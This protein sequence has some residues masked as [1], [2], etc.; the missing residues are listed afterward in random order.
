MV[1]LVKDEKILLGRKTRKIG[2]G[3]RNG[4]GGGIEEGESVYE[5]ATRELFE[6]AGVSCSIDDIKK[7]AELYFEN[8]TEEGPKW[9]LVV[10][11]FLASSW[12]G[13]P[14]ESEEFEDL[15]WFDFADVPENELM[16][17]TFEWLR[18]ILDGKKVIVR[19]KHGPHQKT[20]IGKQK[21]EEVLDF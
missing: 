5:C 11:T 12:Q 20:L 7:S 14:K 8:I 17:G 15:K 18:L 10:H 3:C 2:K 21:I 4:F 13:E 1:F 6:E 19:A 16:A 9:S